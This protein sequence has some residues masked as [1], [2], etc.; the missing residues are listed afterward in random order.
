MKFIDKDHEEF[1]KDDEFL[2][3]SKDDSRK[4][5]L[6]LRHLNKLRKLREIRSFEKEYERERL[7]QIYGNSSDDGGL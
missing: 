5:R 4:P 3:F 7:E 2:Y 1:R 6:T